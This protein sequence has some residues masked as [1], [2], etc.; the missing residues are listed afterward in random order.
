MKA[1]I[2]EIAQW[3]AADIEGDPS[4]VIDDLRGLDQAQPGAL[5]FF[6]NPKYEPQFYTTKASAV[7]VRTAFEPTSPVSA[8]L[9]RVPDPY[10]AFTTLLEKVAALRNTTM[11]GIDAR[12]FIAEDAE[13]GDGA[14]VGPFACIEAGAKV[15]AGARIFPYAYVGKRAQVGADSTLFPHVA[16]YHDCQVGAHCII[17]AGTVIGSDGF[18]FAPQPDGSYRKIPQLGIV[19][20]EDGVEI[21]AN[22]CID[23]ATTGETRIRTGVKLDNLVQIA[24]NVEVGQDSVVAA[25]VGIAGSTRLGEQVMVGGQA[26]FVGHIEVA[27]QTK[28][29]AQ[30]GVNRS[31]K[32]PGQAFRGSPIQPHREQLKS[33]VMFRKLAAMERRIHELEQ[34]MAAKHPQG[35]ADQ[36]PPA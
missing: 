9:L 7:L 16:V 20:L 24:H 31:I 25:Q 13:V 35:T 1:T 22:S 2:G 5:S 14:Y 26:G 28:I 10:L 32:Q 27:D 3:L 19:V 33:E 17:H 6:A 23:R 11:P 15:G 4:Q 12:A 29:D 30:S 34:Q 36:Q 18:G 21:G 8:T